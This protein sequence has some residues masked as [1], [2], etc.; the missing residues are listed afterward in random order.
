MVRR[1]RDSDV[2]KDTH[3]AGSFGIQP[4]F[5]YKKNAAGAKRLEFIWFRETFALSFHI[6]RRKK[7]LCTQTKISLDLLL[8]HAHI[9]QV[10]LAGCWVKTW[11]QNQMLWTV[12]KWIW[13]ARDNHWTGIAATNWKVTQVHQQPWTLLHLVAASDI[14][15]IAAH[16]IFI[17]Y[18]IVLSHN[19]EMLVM[20][21][22]NPRKIKQTCSPSGTINHHHHVQRHFNPLPSSFWC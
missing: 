21:R 14:N 10:H 3:K 20:C 19:L 15:T 4:E 8:P 16:W 13:T 5:D 1:Q 9:S 22:W 6:A 12:L 2:F 11:H 17:P 7:N 18:W